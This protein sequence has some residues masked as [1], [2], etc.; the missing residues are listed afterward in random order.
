M[1]SLV[2]GYV[3]VGAGIGLIGDARADEGGDPSFVNF[4]VDFPGLHRLKREMTG[5]ISARNGLVGPVTTPYRGT[6][7]LGVDAGARQ[8]LDPAARLRLRGEAGASK[9]LRLRWSRRQL[10]AV[11]RSARRAHRRSVLLVVTVRGRPDG[12][13]RDSKRS[14]AFRLGVDGN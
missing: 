6:A 4:Y 7:V 8:V 10:A 11:R 13:D 2:V 12:Q 14:R 9:K 3:L 5:E 1:A